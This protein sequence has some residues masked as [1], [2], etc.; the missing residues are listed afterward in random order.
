[1]S[2]GGFP[3]PA[4]RTS[5]LP[6]LPSGMK[7]SGPGH[8]ER[9]P[10]TQLCPPLTSMARTAATKLRTHPFKAIDFLRS[11]S[12][13]KPCIHFALSKHLIFSRGRVL[14]RAG[15]IPLR[16]MG[17]MEPLLLPF[18]CQPLSGPR[19]EISPHCPEPPPSCSTPGW[20]PP[21]LG[22][23]LWVWGQRYDQAVIHSN[24]RLKE[25]SVLARKEQRAESQ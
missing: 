22:L 10:I 7:L 25:D 16:P 3:H 6:L 19:T 21:A 9:N 15:A 5:L 12:S 8:L 24:L 14:T 1:M 2:Q 4:P 20:S 17:H 18:T 11:G 13:H 23:N